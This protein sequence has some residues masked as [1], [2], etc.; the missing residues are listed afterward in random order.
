MATSLPSGRSLL[1]EAQTAAERAQHDDNGQA[2][3]ETAWDY[4]ELADWTVWI[5]STVK[6]LAIRI[7]C[8]RCYEIMRVVCMVEMF[9]FDSSE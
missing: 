4:C 2:R 8:L 6:L 1:D 5:A 9:V 7:R 3:R